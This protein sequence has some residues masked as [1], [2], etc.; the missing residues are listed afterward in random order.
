M[1]RLGAQPPPDVVHDRLGPVP[2]TERLQGEEDV[3]HQA[4]GVYVLGYNVL[5]RRRSSFIC[6]A[7]AD[8]A[9]LACL[10]HQHLDSQV[11][12]RAG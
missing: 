12:T 4:P 7:G 10:L 5:R 9:E 6:G 1:H 8:S 2:P 3:A 11:S